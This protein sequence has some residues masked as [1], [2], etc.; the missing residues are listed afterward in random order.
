M[1][2]LFLVVDFLEAVAVFRAVALSIQLAVGM[3]RETMFILLLIRVSLVI[4]RLLR[5]THHFIDD[6]IVMMC[7]GQNTFN[8][9]SVRTLGMRLV[10][11]IRAIEMCDWCVHWRMLV[12]EF[13]WDWCWSKIWTDGTRERVEKVGVEGSWCMGELVICHRPTS[14]LVVAAVCRDMLGWLN[15]V[16]ISCVIDRV[17]WVNKAGN[18]RSV[19]TWKS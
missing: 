13:A 5:I 6:Y 12:E 18:S 16:Q 19:R 9:V 15:P 7:F 11:Q 10:P 8:W 3:M 17:T 2:N 4:C 1:A 14:T